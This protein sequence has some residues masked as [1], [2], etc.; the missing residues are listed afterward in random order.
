MY[1]TKS[2]SKPPALCSMRVSK[3]EVGNPWET[4]R[5]GLSAEQRCTIVHFKC[6]GTHPRVRHLPKFPV[7]L[8]YWRE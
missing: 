2:A 5:R 8:Q 7:R 3:N 4:D 6:P 1:R